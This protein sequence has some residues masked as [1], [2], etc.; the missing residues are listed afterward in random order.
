V[1]DELDRYSCLLGLGGVSLKLC[2][3]FSVY[4]LCILRRDLGEDQDSFSSVGFC[5]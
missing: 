3:D 2:G 5:V 1:A 4:R